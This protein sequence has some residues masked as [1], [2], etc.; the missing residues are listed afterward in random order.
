VPSTAPL[1][2][3]PLLHAGDAAVGEYRC[4][5]CGYGVAVSGQLPACPMC[6]AE[7]WVPARWRP[8]S[9]LRPQRPAPFRR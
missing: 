4:T 1:T 5:G 8:F 2:T 3:V 7:T 6:R 9:R